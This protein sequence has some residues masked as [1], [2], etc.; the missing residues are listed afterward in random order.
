MGFLGFMPGLGRRNHWDALCKKRL[1]TVT[2]WEVLGRQW[3]HGSYA[4][5]PCFPG[6]Q[7]VRGHFGACVRLP[8]RRAKGGGTGEVARRSLGVGYEERAQAGAFRHCHRRLCAACSH[9][10]LSAKRW[11]PLR[12]DVALP[13]ACGIKSAHTNPGLLRW[14]SPAHGFHCSPHLRRASIELGVRQLQEAAAEWSRRD[15]W[16]ATL[17][18]DQHSGLCRARV[19][20]EPE[21]LQACSRGADA[22]CAWPSAWG[23]GYEKTSTARQS[24]QPLGGR[25]RH[26]KATRVAWLPLRCGAR[27]RLVRRLPCFPRHSGGSPLWTGHGP[28]PGGFYV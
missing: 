8:R 18:A 12:G 2:K 15:T 14:R 28:D 21:W 23:L 20:P 17:D 9:R 7:G 6:C 27:P 3:R 5:P 4:R 24:H 22:L 10:S 13:P 19:Q 25:A 16:A 11:G 1:R 26:D